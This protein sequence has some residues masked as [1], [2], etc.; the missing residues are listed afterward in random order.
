MAVPELTYALKLKL[1]EW[2]CAFAWADLEVQP[3]ERALI[4]KL[5]EQLQIEEPED[6][7]KVI[8]WLKRPPPVDDLDPYSIPRSAREI[9]VKECE[10]VIRAD[11]VIKAEEAESLAILR[12]VLFG[13]EVGAMKTTGSGDGGG[14]RGAV[15][16]QLNKILQ[17]E[18]AGVSRYLHYSFL[19]FG[20]NRIPIVSFFREQANEGIQHA[21]MMGEKITAFGGHPTIVVQNPPEPPKHDVRT[22]LAE[23]LEFERGGLQEYKN[24]LKMVGDDVA[25]E[26]LVRGQIRAETEHCEEVEKMLRELAK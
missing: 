3:E 9:F 6:R 15:I 1:I 12:K 13:D 16:G 26:E 5:M 21:I 18:L 24:L 2:A 17:L 7:K 11:G 19:V 22:L 20:P 4:L 14:P 10:E 23:S 25:L 8:Q